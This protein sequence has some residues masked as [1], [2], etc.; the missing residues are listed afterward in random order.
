TTTWNSLEVTIRFRTGQIAASA[1]VEKAFMMVELY[2]DDRNAV[3]FMWKEPKGEVQYFRM[4]R[5]PFGTAASPFLLFATMERLFDDHSVE[6]GDVVSR[7]RKNFYVDD[8]LPV[9]D[10]IG[11][12]EKLQ[13]RA[14][15]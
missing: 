7:I 5:V 9:T 1:D 13:E 4:K 3:A 8:C 11:E 10:S 15:M 2:P 14:V 12:M 6:F